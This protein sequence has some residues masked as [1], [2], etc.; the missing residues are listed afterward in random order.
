MAVSTAGQIFR[1]TNKEIEA[2]LKRKDAPAGIASAE[3]YV[4]AVREARRRHLEE[5]EEE[6]EQTD[7]DVTVMEVDQDSEEGG[8]GS[9]GEDGDDE[10]EEKQQE[11]EEEEGEEGNEQAEPAIKKIVDKHVERGRFL[12]RRRWRNTF[13]FERPGDGYWRDEHDDHQI[14][15]FR[16]ASAAD[17]AEAKPRPPPVYIMRNPFCSMQTKQK[18]EKQL[19]MYNLCRKV[20][21]LILTQPCLS[22]S[23]FLFSLSLWCLSCLF[24]SFVY[25]CVCGGG[26]PAARR[27]GAPRF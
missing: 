11:E 7:D 17:L 22:P 3:M 16:D 12:E 2:A 14:K 20:S 5:E 10:E 4:K 13:P 6:E 25:D 18:Y 27:N 15:V 26:L 19:H 23:L 21:G 1:A 8:G 24:L 9:D